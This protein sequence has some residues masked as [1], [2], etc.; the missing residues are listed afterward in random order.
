[1]KK[2]DLIISLLAVFFIFSCE[3]ADRRQ[4][5]SSTDRAPVEINAEVDKARATLGDLITLGITVNWRQDLALEVPDFASRITDL[6]VV[7]TGTEEILEIDGRKVQKKWIKLR[8]EE[9]GSYRVPSLELAYKV[10]GSDE[11]RTAKTAPIFIEVESTLDGKDPE[12]LPNG[13]RPLVPIPRDY[14]NLALIGAVLL[15]ALGVAYLL[16]RR[17]RREKSREVEAPPLAHEV[18]LRRLEHLKKIKTGDLEAIRKLYFDLSEVF[19]RYLQDR[20]NFPAVDWTTEEILPHI[21]RHPGIQGEMEEISRAFFQNTDRVKFA[22]HL[23]GPSEIGRE[24]ET[25]ER[26]IH[27]TKGSGQSAPGTQTLRNG[28]I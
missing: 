17:K 16:W 27:N 24:F 8:A 18:A 19:R 2:I 26:F 1:M 13:I 5:L 15:L 6:K 3:K 14:K 28:E 12:D 4:A 9:L 20:F 22:R 11:E 7:D 25:A 23:P 21:R 10:P